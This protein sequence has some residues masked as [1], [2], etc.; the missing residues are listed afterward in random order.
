[1]VLAIN[2]IIPPNE[3]YHNTALIN[4]F[5]GTVAMCLAARKII[6]PTSWHH[7]PNL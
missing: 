3:W 6:P 1:M 7:D 2:D 4:E 5:N